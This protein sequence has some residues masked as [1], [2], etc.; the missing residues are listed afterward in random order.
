M[1]KIRHRKMDKSYPNDEFLMKCLNSNEV[2][3]NDFL[4]LKCWIENIK[5]DIPLNEIDVKL[6]KWTYDSN[7]K[8]WYYEDCKIETAHSTIYKAWMPDHGLCVYKLIKNQY[9]DS[10][11]ECEFVKKYEPWTVPYLINLGNGLVYPFK[12]YDVDIYFRNKC[13]KDIPNEAF[14]RH[15]ICASLIVHHKFILN[16]VSYITNVLNTLYKE[17]ILWLDVKLPN[18]LYGNDKYNIIDVGSF[19]Y[20]DE[21][22]EDE[23]YIHPTFLTSHRYKDYNTFAIGL[24]LLEMICTRVSYNALIENSDK[25]VEIIN[26]NKDHNEICSFLVNVLFRCF[27]ND[28]RIFVHDTA[29]RPIPWP[30]LYKYIT[31][32]LSYLL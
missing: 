28:L 17:K 11:R 10:F 5:I 12:G 31:E 19:T 2:D 25:V 22:K 4:D 14:E 23:K 21:N 7:N 16:T 15:S 30:E 24:I 1:T 8:F 6:N 26:K 3:D 29:E 9:S 20:F 13:M 27:G 18:V 32:S